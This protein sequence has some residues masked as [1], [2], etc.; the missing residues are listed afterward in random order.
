MSRRV[1]LATRVALLP[2]HHT[3]HPVLPD[4]GLL[5]LG[6]ANYRSAARL[7]DTSCTRG[8]MDTFSRAG[9]TS[10]FTGNQRP[11][12]STQQSQRFAK[13]PTREAARRIGLIRP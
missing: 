6:G 13:R 7:A 5:P 4:V 9:I 1:H 12:T 10:H 2:W 8:I 3:E 11:A